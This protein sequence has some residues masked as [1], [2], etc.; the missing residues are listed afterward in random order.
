MEQMPLIPDAIEPST[1]GIP[2]TTVSSE[3]LEKILNL[4]E[5]HFADIKAIE[6]SP[7]KLT[8]T[9]SAFANAEGGELYIGIDEDKQANRRS[10][11]GF[12]KPEDANGHI[13]ALEQRFPL[14]SNYQYTFLRANTQHGYVLKIDVAK[15]ADIVTAADN[16]AYLRR[17]AMCIPQTTREQL[18]RLRFNKGLQ[19]FENQTVSVELPAI[20]NSEPM[21]EFMLNVVPSAE[22]ESW[23]KKQRLVRDGM[24]TVAAVILFA[25][26]PQ[27]ILPKRCGIKIYR[28]KTRAREGTRET[29]AF[30]PITV[31]GYMYQQ[32]YGAVDITVEVVESVSKLGSESLESISYPR[33][34]LHEII[35]NAVLHRDYSLADDVHV[36]V[37]DNRIE[38]ESPGKLPAHITPE[39]ILSERFSR[40]GTLVRLIN[41][42]PN[43]PNKDVGEGLNTA[44]NA[45]RKLR[46][47]EPLIEERENTVLVNIRHEMLASPEELIMKYL[48]DN[49]EINNRTA[50]SITHIEQDYVVKRIF[51]QMEDRGIIER[52]PGTDR[53]TTAYRLKA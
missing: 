7:G 9:M 6:I 19:S 2:I 38:V 22:P 26:E 41:K 18:E 45:M 50:R 32:I 39:N 37:F 34:A 11:R 43:P 1:Q 10:W 49:R 42:F 4:T 30:D 27:A 17:S 36:R 21:L 23:L 25:E 40:N 16:V 44:F 47:K 8:K 12:Q 48:S 52:V 13:Q 28:Y 14:G 53:A 51:G 33:E 31:E 20:S 3:Q 35:T 24:P 46:L 5:G 29:L 15:S